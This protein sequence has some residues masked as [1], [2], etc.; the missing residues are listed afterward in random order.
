[1][2]LAMKH[3]WMPKPGRS[4]VSVVTLVAAGLLSA[5]GC[6]KT[7]P[8]YFV[9][10]EVELTHRDFTPE[11]QQQVADVLYA[12]FGTPDQPYVLKATG[13]SRAKVETASGPVFSDKQGRARG[14]YRQ[15]C[16]HCHGTTGDGDGP[17]AALLNPYPRD[18]RRGL[19]KF[20]STER[21]AEPTD[22]DLEHVIRYG[23]P[24]TAMPAFDLL[25]KDDVA[26]LV[27]YVKYLS[28]RGQTEYA[29]AAAI[30]DLSE[31]E[32]LKE[33]Y[34]TL[35][36]EILSPIAQRWADANKAIIQPPPKPDWNITE[37]VALGRELFYGAKANCVKCHGPSE[38][39][40]G[41]TT[42]YD[43]WTKP[44]VEYAKEVKDGLKTIPS[45]PD[46]T[47]AEKSERI[48]ELD[49]LAKAL[50][51]TTL[52]TRNILPRNLR[53]GIYRGG[54]SPLDLFR[55]IH[56]GINGAPMPGVGPP[57]PGQPGVLTPDEIWHLVDYVRQLPYEPIN[58]TPKPTTF[59]G[60][61]Q[62]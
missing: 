5:V 11:Q 34:P 9:L 50:A 20:K 62:L 24:G 21:A 27:E 14:I 54:G 26:A 43:D 25:P 30:G 32:S 2:S 39:G 40:D 52:P 48:N 36:E 59:S 17:T 8:A 53:A 55:R 38:L 49:E 18:Y 41:Q 57:S 4:I 31:G 1:M 42:D 56:S 46:M 35:V 22:H 60:Q 23:V 33:D 6:G 16:G 45:D 61:A 44:L 3:N 37:S 29:L 12:M 58:Q 13:L 51:D 28:I 7:T 10:N 15:Q 47:S 19:F